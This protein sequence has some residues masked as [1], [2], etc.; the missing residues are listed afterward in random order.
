MGARRGVVFCALGGFAQG[1]P[2]RQQAEEE[3]GRV[4]RPPTALRRPSDA[5]ST[6]VRHFIGISSVYLRY[7]LGMTSVFYWCILDVFLVYSWFSG[8][9]AV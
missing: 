4:S 3:E 1:H 5:P 9:A 2:A 8:E 6:V 7:I